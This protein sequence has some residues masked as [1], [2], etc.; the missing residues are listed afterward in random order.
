MKK[1]DEIADPSSCWNKARNEEQLFILLGRDEAAPRT[2]REWCRLR[3]E[4]GKNMPGDP[5]VISALEKANDI[6]ME[7]HGV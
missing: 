5:Q 1:K 7:Q 2:I 6:E 3:I 4:L